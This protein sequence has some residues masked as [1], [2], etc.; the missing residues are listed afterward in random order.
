MVDQLM[1][2]D[3]LM[4]AWYC[5]GG[6][7]W[8]IS[9]N[10][11]LGECSVF[12]NCVRYL[13][14]REMSP[15]KAVADPWPDAM[16]TVKCVTSSRSREAAWQGVMSPTTGRK[17]RWIQRIS[18]A[19]GHARAWAKTSLEGWAGVAVLIRLCSVY[20]VQNLGNLI[21]VVFSFIKVHCL[22]FFTNI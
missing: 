4:F 8:F 3:F 10:L 9:S 15:S 14:A 2:K 21:F 12:N 18:V 22:Y 13:D 11:C 5:F 7:S 6:M 16:W 19:N 1:N 17:D 20:K